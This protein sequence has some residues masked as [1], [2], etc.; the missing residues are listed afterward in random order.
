[1]KTLILFPVLG[2]LGL[3]LC[4]CQTPEER[5]ER[6]MDEMVRQLDQMQKTMD[7]MSEKMDAMGK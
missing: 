7:R 6:Q 2:V 3:L 1:M 4:G 5:M